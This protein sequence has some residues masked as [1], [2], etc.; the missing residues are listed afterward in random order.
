MFRHLLL[1]GYKLIILQFILLSIV[2]GVS[3]FVSDWRGFISVLLGGGAWIVPSLYFVRKLFKSNM[4]D[5]QVLLKDFLCGEGI[6]LLLSAGLI[7]F[8]VF[9]VSIKTGAF[10]SGYIATIAASFFMPFWLSPCCIDTVKN[11]N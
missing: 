2:A 8:I 11:D 3:I 9:F 7:I 4:R 6:K 1:T 5:A 10:L